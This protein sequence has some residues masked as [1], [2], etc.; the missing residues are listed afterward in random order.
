MVNEDLK[1]TDVSF[2]GEYHDL[3]SQVKFTSI[4][5]I[6]KEKF[7]TYTEPLLCEYVLD[8]KYDKIV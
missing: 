3:I 2:V 5:E 6:L 1:M 8:G 7:K 4:R